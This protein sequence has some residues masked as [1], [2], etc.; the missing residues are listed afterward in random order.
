MSIVLE[1]YNPLS[2]FAQR[3]AQTAQQDMAFERQMQ[4]KAMEQPM[5]MGAMTGDPRFMQRAHQAIGTPFSR[6][7]QPQGMQT[8]M[9]EGVERGPAGGMEEF[10]AGIQEASDPFDPRL[11]MM[12]QMGIPA[13]RAKR[14]FLS[15][16]RLQEQKLRT[17]AVG[18]QAASMMEGSV[19]LSRARPLLDDV[20]QSLQSVKTGPLQSA[21]LAG[22]LLGIAS[23]DLGEM[24]ETALSSEELTQLRNRMAV[25]GRQ[26][27]QLPGESLT[28]TQAREIGQKLSTRL[29]ASALLS[30]IQELERVFTLESAASTV[31][32]EL[33]GI[34]SAEGRALTAADIQQAYQI[35]SDVMK[36]LQEEQNELSA[37][38]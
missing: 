11:L 2:D 4:A 15:Q 8:E 3:L 28:A 6:M 10:F 7:L 14:E 19:A 33:R 35:A 38:E 27:A 26:L 30:Q 37:R 31:L 21:S 22:S 32:E 17:E 13:A 24:A 16:Q 34:A 12:E 20:I 9:V 29:P 18:K 5:S 36:E 1:Q 25:L 23:K